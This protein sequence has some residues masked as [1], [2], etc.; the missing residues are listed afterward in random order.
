MQTAINNSSESPETRNMS[1]ENLQEN[2]SREYSAINGL[3]APSSY[4]YL[5]PKTSGQRYT[6]VG[7]DIPATV[8]T[9]VSIVSTSEVE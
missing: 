8:T 5:E 3:Y 4:G 7:P 6:Y 1:Y 9:D 2:E